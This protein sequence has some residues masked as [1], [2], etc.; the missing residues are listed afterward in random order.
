[1]RY[2]VLKGKSVVARGVGTILD[3]SSNGAAFRPAGPVQRGELIELSISWPVTLPD[4]IPVRLVVIGKVIRST[5]ECAVCVIGQYEFRTQARLS[6]APAALSAGTRVLAWAGTA[7]RSDIR[8][9][10]NG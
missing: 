5:A 8:A 3:I 10:A 9:V 4:E 2:K 7:G 1:M 6:Q